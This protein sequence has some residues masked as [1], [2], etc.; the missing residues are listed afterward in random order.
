MTACIFN[1]NINIIQIV[2]NIVRWEGTFWHLNCLDWLATCSRDCNHD[3]LNDQ[4]QD[5]ALKGDFSIKKIEAVIKPFKLG[6]VKDGLSKIG[7]TGQDA[8]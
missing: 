5:K 8:I 7:V 3:R 2:K 1:Q 4:D 6:D